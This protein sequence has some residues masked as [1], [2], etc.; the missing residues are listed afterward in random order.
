MNDAWETDNDSD[1]DSLQDQLDDLTKRFLLPD[2][3][4]Q[5]TQTKQNGPETRTKRAE[6][7]SIL[8]YIRYLKNTYGPAS[9]E[10][11]RPIPYTEV[12]KLFERVEIWA[13]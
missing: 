7:D 4:T 9:T 3:P 5:L 13:R 6:S 8:Q 2:Q 10:D 11:A 1:D 12:A